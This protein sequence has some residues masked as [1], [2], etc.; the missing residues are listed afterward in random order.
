MSASYRWVLA[1][2]T[3]VGIAIAK[4]AAAPPTTFRSGV[5]RDT[6]VGLACPTEFSLLGMTYMLRGKLVPAPLY[7][8]IQ[9]IKPKT[10][11]ELSEEI[12]NC[13]SDSDAACRHI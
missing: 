1:A 6:Y 3:A 11:G 9:T 5:S 7:S 8:T 13:V 4:R 12:T 10:I 2:C